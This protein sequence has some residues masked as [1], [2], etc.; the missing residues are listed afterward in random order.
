MMKSLATD[1][2]II[3]SARYKREVGLGSRRVAKA[4]LATF[5]RSLAIKENRVSSITELQ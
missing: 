3:R 1:L 2:S 4:D 5:P